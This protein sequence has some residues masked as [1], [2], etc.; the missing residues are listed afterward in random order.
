[1]PKRA[2]KGALFQP[3][4][5]EPVPTKSTLVVEA[6]AQKIRSG[7]LRPGD[8]LPSERE[9]AA[10]LGV[11]RPAVR[12]AIAALQLAGL[13]ESRVGDGTY[14]TFRLT[15]PVELLLAKAQEVLQTS[16]S[17][18][19]VLTL[20]R[21]L[22]VGSARLAVKR[23]TPED[24]QH[25]RT[26]WERKKTLALAGKYEEYLSVA[27]EFHLALARATHSPAV[28]QVV[29]EVLKAIHQPL[30]RAMRVSFYRKD[31]QHIHA[32]LAVHEAI[33]QAFLARDVEAVTQAM[34]LH[35][36]MQIQQLYEG[37]K[38]KPHENQD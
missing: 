31:P 11:S 9:L 34:E 35:F 22:E 15:Q 29:A 12:E 4:V 16:Q 21:V 10:Q 14:V 30:W 1:M 32:M 23:A 17:P 36:D 38:E 8:R 2:E 7:E 20:R 25:I 3:I 5:P 26:I 27:E 28:V 6:I 19:E 18:L 13:L 24:D 37:S 33:L